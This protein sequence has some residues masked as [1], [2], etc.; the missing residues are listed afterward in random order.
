M[1]YP[2]FPIKF[3]HRH[4]ECTGM[5]RAKPACKDNPHEPRNQVNELT[6]FLDLSQVYGTTE[7]KAKQ[8]RKNDGNYCFY[9]FLKFF[10]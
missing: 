9:N 7:K 6:S 8:L 10:K 5:G 4:H 1:K 2:C 3:D